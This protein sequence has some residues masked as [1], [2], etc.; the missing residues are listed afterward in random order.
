MRT[1]SIQRTELRVARYFL[2]IFPIHFESP[3]EDNLLYK[4]K[5]TVP[6]CP[7]FGDSTVH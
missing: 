2:S 4:D 1:I 6:K 7:L 3:K 5:E